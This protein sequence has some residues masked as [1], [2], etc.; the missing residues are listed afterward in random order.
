MIVVN[1]YEAK[2]QLSR[3]IRQALDGERV[4][5]ARSGKPLVELK[6]YQP[7]PRRIRGLLKGKLQVPDDFDEPLPDLEEAIYGADSSD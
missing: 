6:P 1:S 2:T 4:V 7:Q 3:L 5:I